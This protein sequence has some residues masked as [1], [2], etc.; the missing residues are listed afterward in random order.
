MGNKCPLWFRV[1]RCAEFGRVCV[2]FI[3]DA[4]KPNVNYCAIVLPENFKKLSEALQSKVYNRWDVSDKSPPKERR[5]EAA[6]ENHMSNL[7][8]EILAINREVPHWPDVIMSKFNPGSEE[9]KA[10]AEM[11]KSFETEFEISQRQQPVGSRE[12]NQRCSGV[13]DYAVEGGR[14]PLDCTRCVDLAHMPLA[15]FA[16]KERLGA[17]A[18]RANK[19]GIVVLKDFSVW[20]TNVTNQEMKVDAGELFG[21]GTAGYSDGVF[22]F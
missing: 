22:S 12:G 14:S 16:Q 10:L 8:L 3:L 7:Q 13:C 11:K 17:S 2:D 18:G 19:P 9:H 5:R 6:A 20:L 15:E 1:P 4:T 21:F